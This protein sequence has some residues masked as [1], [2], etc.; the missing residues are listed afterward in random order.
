METLRVIMKSIS[1]GEQ[2]NLFAYRIGMFI[3][4]MNEIDMTL[5]AAYRT[6]YGVEK[7]ASKTF[8][9]KTM[10]E[11]IKSVLKFVEGK[12]PNRKKLGEALIEVQSMLWIR[13]AI[14]HG[15]ICGGG[16]APSYLNLITF[17]QRGEFSP[18]S[19]IEHIDKIMK[20]GREVNVALAMIS[21]YDFAVA[22]GQA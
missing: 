15:F 13:N 11:R 5:V 18:E 19:L 20:L 3:L 7:P 17:N 10:A 21:S 14:A 9:D 6:I 4:V 22:T 1:L 16:D 8:I 12:D 2:R